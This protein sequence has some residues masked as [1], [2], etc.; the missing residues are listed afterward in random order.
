MQSTTTF[1]G[2][3]ETATTGKPTRKVSYS[4]SFGTKNGKM[5]LGI[6]TNINGVI[7]KL[8]K[9]NIRNPQTWATDPK[10]RKFLESFK[11]KQK[12]TR[13]RR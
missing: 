2:L 13:K 3:F 8:T 7:R 11:Q 10:V 1:S 6:Q 12:P 4:G 9:N 5:S